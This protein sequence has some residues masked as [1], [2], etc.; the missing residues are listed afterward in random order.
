MTTV[1]PT[2]PPILRNLVFAITGAWARIDATPWVV[3][4]RGRIGARG[5]P[6]SWRL[7]GGGEGSGEGAGR[8]CMRMDGVPTDQVCS[9][10]SW[11][12]FPKVRG[13]SGSVARKRRHRI[14]RGTDFWSWCAGSEQY[15]QG[16]PITSAAS[17][18]WD[19]I[20]MHHD[21]SIKYD[22]PTVWYTKMETT[23]IPRPNTCP[24]LVKF[25]DSNGWS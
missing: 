11:M 16:W 3:C 22:E 13:L 5:M 18:A 4:V 9:T 7:H 19:T 23:K 8:R 20:G 1:F 24:Q 2:L 17:R 10:R 6:Q 25:S 12:E 14:H 21:N 15:A